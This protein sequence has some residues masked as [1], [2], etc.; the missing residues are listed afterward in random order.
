MGEIKIEEDVV[1]F[2]FYQI[3]GLE[4]GR[5]VLYGDF[6]CF[7]NVYMEKGN[8]LVIKRYFYRNSN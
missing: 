6:N 7:D 2:G 1:V 4:T 3:S 8:F 5:I